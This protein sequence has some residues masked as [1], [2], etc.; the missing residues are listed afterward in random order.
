MLVIIHSRSTPTIATVRLSQV[1]S[2]LWDAPV[3]CVAEGSACSVST[4]QAFARN[5][6]S[7]ALPH[8]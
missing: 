6:D 1:H 7:Q 4:T 2:R 3:L 8:S 5:A